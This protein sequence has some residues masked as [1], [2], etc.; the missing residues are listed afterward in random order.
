MNG[1][2]TAIWRRILYFKFKVCWGLQLQKMYR[3]T[4]ASN[5]S[6]NSCNESL[7]QLFKGLACRSKPIHLKRYMDNIR[8]TIPLCF[9][10]HIYSYKAVL[11]FL[12]TIAIFMSIFLRFLSPLNC[13]MF[14]YI[15]HNH[16][17]C[18]PAIKTHLQFQG[19]VC[20]AAAH[21]S[22]W[23]MQLNLHAVL[24]WTIKS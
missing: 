18:I 20:G 9:Y 6:E 8:Y 3:Q 14:R 19:F 13:C 21:K 7:D 16:F 10:K 11:S 17:H 5:I 2:R 15:L 22:V 1:F 24:F 23:I 12:T 4:I